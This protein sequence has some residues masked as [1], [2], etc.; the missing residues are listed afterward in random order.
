MG[1]K[2][3]SRLS[4]AQS[5]QT[6]FV[7][8]LLSLLVSFCAAVRVE[9]LSYVR[10]AWTAAKPIQVSSYFDTLK[11]LPSLKHGRERNRENNSERASSQP[12][13]TG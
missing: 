1:P 7:N 13:L 4:K 9:L 8:D 11:H 5:L 12:L 6:L 3:S 10:G 2:V